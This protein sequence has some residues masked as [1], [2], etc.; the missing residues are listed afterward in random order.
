ME[1]VERAGEQLQSERARRNEL[2]AKKTNTSATA[3]ETAMSQYATS[4]VQARKAELNQPN[5]RIAKIAPTVSWKIC[6]NTRQSRLNPRCFGERGA[7][8]AAV[9]ILES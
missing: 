6:F 8:L 3:T 5:A 1:H 4:R 9:D 7:I 2:T